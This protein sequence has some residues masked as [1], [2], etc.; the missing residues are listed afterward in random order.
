MNRDIPQLLAD[1]MNT[2][3]VQTI[4]RVLKQASERDLEG[5]AVLLNT[6][7][8]TLCHYCELAAREI[9]RRRGQGQPQ[10]QGAGVVD[11]SL[12]PIKDGK[13]H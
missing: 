9:D 1:A 11:W 6:L 7:H 4:E 3:D 8:D 13:V 10:P 2:N 12:H 5:V